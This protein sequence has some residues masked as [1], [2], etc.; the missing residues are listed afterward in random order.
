MMALEFGI[1][2]FWGYGLVYMYVTVKL[3]ILGQH[4]VFVYAMARAIL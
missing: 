2:S 3:A 1:S 4:N